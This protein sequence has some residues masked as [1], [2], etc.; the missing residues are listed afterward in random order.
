MI[1][2]KNFHPEI[3]RLLDELEELKDSSQYRA[4][5]ITGPDYY[6][7]TA[8]ENNLRRAKAQSTADAYEF[9]QL[10]LRMLNI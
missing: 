7:E 5:L 9:C 6:F 10:R 2:H 8:V 4:N 1:K 3:C